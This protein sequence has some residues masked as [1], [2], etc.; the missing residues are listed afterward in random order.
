MMSNNDD[1][2]AG[3]GLSFILLDMCVI[4]CV[5]YGMCIICIYIYVYVCVYI[6][7]CDCTCNMYDCMIRCDF[8]SRSP[9]DLLI[10]IK[11][12][13]NTKNSTFGTVFYN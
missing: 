12:T 3:S 5:I 1:F 8:L 10:S 7:L 6:H 13:K 2:L 4:L 11:K 9:T